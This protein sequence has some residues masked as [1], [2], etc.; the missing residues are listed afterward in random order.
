[1][2]LSLLMEFSLR[3]MAARVESNSLGSKVDHVHL[4]LFDQ[5]EDLVI[6][7]YAGFARVTKTTMP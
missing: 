5:G 6:G 7:V 1:M 4:W 2:E 3:W